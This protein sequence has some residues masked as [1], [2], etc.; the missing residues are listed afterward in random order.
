MVHE[1]R[2]SYWVA[3][4]CR[5]ARLAEDHLLSEI[6]AE[7]RVDQATV[8]R[9]ETGRMREIDLDAMV[10]AYARDLGLQA[11]DLWRRALELWADAGD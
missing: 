8:G 5:D 7:R 1:R 10:D 4:V 2:M 11:R 9:F 6:A 3:Q